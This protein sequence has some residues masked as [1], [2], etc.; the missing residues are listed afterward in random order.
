MN[1][2][3]DQ[4]SIKARAMMAKRDTRECR[5][6]QMPEPEAVSQDQRGDLIGWLDREL[7]RLP[8]KYRMPIVLCELEGKTHRQAADQLGWPI[9]TVSG[10]LSMAGT[11]LARRLSRPGTSLSV[12]APGSCCLGMSR[13]RECR[14]GGFTPRLEPRANRR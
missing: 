3:R 8:D 13:G 11:M 2:S 9:G 12:Q 6:T 10:R 1:P 14:P 5:V 7:S 4:T